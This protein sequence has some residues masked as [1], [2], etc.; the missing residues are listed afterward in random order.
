MKGRPL[1][2]I[3][4]SLL[5]PLF[6]GV[7]SQTEIPRHSRRPLAVPT[8]DGSG[9]V[10]HPD[11]VKF[12]TPWKGYPYWMAVTPY[13]HMKEEYENPSILVSHDGLRWSVP[14]GASNPLVPRPERG[15][16]ADPDMIYRHDLDELWI[17]FLET[18]RDEDHHLKLIR[19]PDGRSWSGSVILSTIP[20]QE[21]RSP[22][23]AHDGARF[24]MWSVNVTRGPWIECRESQ[25][26]MSWSEPT[27]VS[28]DQPGYEPSHLDVQYSASTQ[29]YSMILQAYP[30]GG[31]A[32]QL[33]WADCQ[34]GISWRTFN[35]PLLSTLNAPAWA[36]QTLY[37]ATFAVDEPGDL[38]QI[39]Y[40][41]RSQKNE[42]RIG[43]TC[44]RASE[45]ERILG[46]SQ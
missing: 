36:K 11:V 25:D 35:R 43:Y 37:R 15:F 40:S 27:R 1:I 21:I 38:V 19:S 42:N 29:R 34:D 2:A 18:H 13:P 33:F 20:Y 30:M 24:R 5:R 31:G 7:S 12:K 16:N 39:W 4:S 10:V 46:A 8:Y 41:G 45:L 6:Y 32:S 3:A 23:V 9:Q 26:G 28:L 14:D 17:Y 22:A 44:A